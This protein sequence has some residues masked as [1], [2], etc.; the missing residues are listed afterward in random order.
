MNL[1]QLVTVIALTFVSFLSFAQ[2]ADSTLIK[3]EQ[4][5]KEIEQLKKRTNTIDKIVKKLDKLKVS[6]YIQTEFQHG[7]QDAT[8]KVGD[9]NENMDK[10]FNRIGVRRGRLKFEYTDGIG[11]AAVQIEVNDKGVSFRDLY[12]GV[13]DPWIGRNSVMLG[14]FNRPFGYEVGYS[15]SNLES[16]ERATIIQYFFPDERDLGA[17]LTLQTK[18]ESKLHFLK[19]EAG[20]FA[21]N[22]INKE[23]DN[24]KDFIGRLS[25][26]KEI[27]SWGKW[28]LGTSYYNGSVYN[29]TTAS[30][31]MSGKYFVES[32]EANT[33]TYMKREYV[34]FDGQ[35]S[36][37]SSWGKTTVRAEG[38][39]GVQPGIAS[40]SKSPNSSK[41]PTDEPENAL[42]AR[43]FNGYF[44]YLIHDILSS[45]FSAVLKYDVYDPNTKVAGNEVG[46]E[47]SFTSKTD[48]AQSTMAVGGLWRINKNLRVQAYYEFKANEKSEHV[49]G[50]TAERLEDMFTLRLQYKF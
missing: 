50:Y 41:R 11:R 18:K 16:P 8:L 15:T 24:R 29:P 45:P 32:T 19:L 25:A 3:L 44:F 21:G 7:Q 4:Q 6:A 12:I 14:V 48:L 35:F 38:L 1:K 30:Y 26:T 49:E 9:K 33:G 23:T 17:M 31:R 34:G 2:E 46:V 20:I 28:G 42:Y 40:S 5:A 27:G 43:N 47:N 36:A 39:F 22:S 37:K 10:S 13:K